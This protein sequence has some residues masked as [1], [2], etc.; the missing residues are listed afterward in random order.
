LTELDPAHIEAELRGK[1]RLVYWHFV[2][3]GDD[4]IGVRGVQRALNFSSPSVASHHLEKLRRLG[5]LSKSSIGEYA[6][7]G[8]IKVGFL[9]L[10]VRLGRLVLPRYLFYAVM[11]SSMLVT[12]LLVYPQSL[13]NVHNAVALLFGALACLVLW[14]EAVQVYRAAPF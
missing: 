1:T 2:R 10:F 3:R 9:K 14:Y 11:F 12:Y 5:L 4:R 13:A 6:L 7:V 8:E